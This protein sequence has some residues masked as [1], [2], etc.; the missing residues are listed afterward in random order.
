MPVRVVVMLEIVEV[1]YKQSERRSA[2]LGPLQLV[3]ELAVEET[4]VVK[5]GEAVLYGELLQFLFRGLEPAR[6]LYELCAHYIEVIREVLQLVGGIDVYVE[7]KVALGYLPRPL[8]YPVDGPED[9]A[10]DRV[11]D[12][13]DAADGEGEDD[14]H[15]LAEVRE[16]L[17]DHLLAS[18][19]LL[20]VAVV[21]P[22]NERLRLFELRP[23]ESAVTQVLSV[24]PIY[25]FYHHLLAALVA[26]LLEF[27]Q[28]GLELFPVLAG[29]EGVEAAVPVDEPVGAQ[30]IVLVEE[31]L[32]VG[33]VPR[34]FLELYHLVIIHEHDLEAHIA[35]VERYEE[36]GHERHEDGHHLVGKPQRERPYY[37]VGEDKGGHCP[38]DLDGDA[39]ELEEE[40]LVE[41]G[42]QEEGA[43]CRYQPGEDRVEAHR[44]GPGDEISGVVLGKN[45]GEVPLGEPAQ[46]RP[47]E[48]GRRKTEEVPDAGVK[49]AQI[50]FERSG[51]EHYCR[52]AKKKYV[53]QPSQ[54]M[55]KAPA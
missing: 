39:R 13:K 54:L 3:R 49:L 51:D 29:D 32:E 4:V 33:E 50:D 31:A 27:G 41:I 52:S 8:P 40:L 21:Y 36:Q 55:G 20:F 18:G 2:P 6:A 28:Y 24:Q 12:E 17:P 48:Q 26:H 53:E 23:V 5:A 25:P 37:S 19:K 1:H 38:E 47:G 22:F 34:L 44:I 11:P 7:L 16:G 9:H 30:V 15:H 10:V 14:E 35:R 45:G 43:F 42:G 46:G